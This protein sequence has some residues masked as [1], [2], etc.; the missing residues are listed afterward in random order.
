MLIDR[1]YET[2]LLLVLI[3]SQDRKTSD[4]ND[5]NQVSIQRFFRESKDSGGALSLAGS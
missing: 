1:H 3:T 4:N 2:G 5:L